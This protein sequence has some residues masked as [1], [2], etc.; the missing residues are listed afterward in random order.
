MAVVL[1]VTIGH[2]SPISYTKPALFS[3]LTTQSLTHLG[4]L[5]QHLYY[6]LSI[7]PQRTHFFPGNKNY[8]EKGESSHILRNCTEGDTQQMTVENL[9]SW[10]KMLLLHFMAGSKRLAETRENAVHQ[11]PVK[12]STEKVITMTIILLVDIV[13]GIFAQEVFKT[14]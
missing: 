3:N 12:L 11:V 10:V 13:L 4:N 14:P 8:L 9:I 2:K 7:P 5:I 1:T 6:C